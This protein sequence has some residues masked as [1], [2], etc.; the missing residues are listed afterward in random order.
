MLALQPSAK[1]TAPTTCAGPF[2][3]IQG[4]GLLASGAELGGDV[5][6]RVLQLATDGIDGSDDHYRNAGG[7]ETVFDSGCA[8]LVVQEILEYEHV[9]LLGQRRVRYGPTYAGQLTKISEAVPS[10]CL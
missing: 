1:K 5:V 6:E 7:D 8:A 9:V 10:D 4:D 2:Q 3:W